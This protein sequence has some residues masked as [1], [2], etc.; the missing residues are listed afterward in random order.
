MS[1]GTSVIR[2]FG[3]NGE[4]TEEREIWAKQLDQPVVVDGVEFDGSVDISHYAVCATTEDVAEKVASVSG[5][6]LDGGSVLDIKFLHRNS[7]ENPTLNVNGT[8]AKPILLTGETAAGPGAW[9]A[10]KAVR[11]LYDGNGWVIVGSAS[12][13]TEITDEDEGTRYTVEAVVLDGHL[14]LSFENI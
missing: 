8:G 11:L 1:E 5:F 14:V 12:G 13:K 3:A 7:A 6:V 2:V 10:G 4:V 9:E